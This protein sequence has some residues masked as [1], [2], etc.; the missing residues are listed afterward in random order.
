MKSFY[1]I[2][3]ILLVSFLV[4]KAVYFGL[5]SMGDKVYAGQGIGKVNQY[6]A[7]KDTTNVLIFGSSRANHS[8]DPSYLKTSAFNMGVDGKTINYAKALIK[9]LPPNKKQLI[10]LQIDPARM[11]ETDYVGEDVKQL[12]TKYH[13]NKLIKEEINA[14]NLENPLQHFYWTLD[15]NGNVLPIIKNYFYPKYDH[16]KYNGYD[17][18]TLTTEQKEIL[19]KVL[20]SNKQDYCE[21][22]SINPKFKK[23][24]L[25]II[26]YATINK[27]TLVVFTSPEYADICKEDNDLLRELL[28]KNNVE[29]YDFSDHFVNNNE[30]D[31][32]KDKIH[33]S[34]KGA[35]LFSI[36]FAEILNK[37][38]LTKIK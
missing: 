16:T 10:V 38:I 15:F 26:D 23:A 27:K 3:G 19:L 14:L 35:Q 6:L 20:K 32:W 5:N 33:L 31:Y 12:K 22:V 34:E 18:I 37:R 8:L 28:Q 21:E 2:L 7:L 29:Y 9:T 36:Y 13:S 30:I 1:L 17:P 4:D 11:V 25:G 24:I